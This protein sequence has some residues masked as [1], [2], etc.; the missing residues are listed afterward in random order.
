MSERTK[1]TVV[2]GSRFPPGSPEES[3]HRIY[4]ALCGAA[5]RVGLAGG[6]IETW[7]L[8][9]ETDENQSVTGVRLTFLVHGHESTVRTRLAT[10]TSRL[11]QFHHQEI[12]FNEL[13]REL[14]MSHSSG[15]TIG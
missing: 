4:V 1:F 11:L 2:E 15:G 5:N 12:Y 13:F 6:H 14:D 7:A 3:Q 9:V 10:L 8:H